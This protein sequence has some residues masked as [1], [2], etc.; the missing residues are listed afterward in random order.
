MAN[1]TK[2]TPEKEIVILDALRQKPV[3][4]AACRKARISNVAFHAWRRD[5]PAF[6]ER[7]RV[8]R[9]EGYDALEDALTTRAMRD[10][11]TAAIFMLKSHRR[12]IYGDKVD[13]TH[14]GL[15]T[16]AA[17]WVAVREAIYEALTPYPD[18][19]AAVMGRLNALGAGDG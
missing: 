13:H 3:Y 8:A 6:A 14:R 2:R 10:D 9:E 4:S 15:I 5:D 11:T 19:L 12:A 1:I 17:D 18:A 16:F 7:V